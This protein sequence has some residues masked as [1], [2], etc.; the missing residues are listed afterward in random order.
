MRELE[1]LEQVF[2]LYLTASYHG[3]GTP[4]ETGN[5]ISGVPT[6]TKKGGS[7]TQLEIRDQRFYAELARLRK[8]TGRLANR[9][10]RRLIR[11]AER[12]FTRYCNTCGTKFLGDEEALYCASCLRERGEG[13]EG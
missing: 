6:V 10:Y 11:I 8:D 5:V 9:Y 12:S 1:M 3:L 13:K 7:P 2:D 4:A